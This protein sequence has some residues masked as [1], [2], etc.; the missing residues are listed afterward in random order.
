MTVHTVIIVDGTKGNS[1]AFIGDQ[2]HANEYISSHPNEKVVAHGTV[3]H[4]DENGIL[5][6]KIIESTTPPKKKKS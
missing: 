3:S 1:I 5:W 2:Y 4:V 6:L